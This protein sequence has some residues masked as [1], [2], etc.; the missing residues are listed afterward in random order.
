M[1][2]SGNQ[3]W[4]A[5]TL[6][7]VCRRHS[8]WV[9]SST[10]EARARA[11]ART[12][13]VASKSLWGTSSSWSQKSSGQHEPSGARLG[14]RDRPSSLKSQDKNLNRRSQAP[15]PFSPLFHCPGQLLH[16]VIISPEVLQ[17]PGKVPQGAGTHGC[18][19]LTRTRRDMPSHS[20][21]KSTTV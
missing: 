16:Q 8:P 2:N 18:I 14:V 10:D 20:Y 9:P 13:L 21:F 12:D 7:V 4:R 11:R 3:H 6:T 5:A 15:L 19:A 1:P 17:A